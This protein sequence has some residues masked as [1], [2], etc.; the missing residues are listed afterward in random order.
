[1]KPSDLVHVAVSVGGEVVRDHAFDMADRLL[2]YVADEA[3][4][5]TIA[6]EVVRGTIFR[7]LTAAYCAGYLAVPKAEVPS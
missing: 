5:A 1:M 2:A 3:G 7:A 4:E 6:D